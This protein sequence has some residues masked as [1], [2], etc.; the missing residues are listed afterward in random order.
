MDRPALHMDKAQTAAWMGYPAGLVGIAA[1]D[2]DHDPLHQ[3]LC[4]WLGVR[5]HSMRDAA[6]EPLTHDE[7]TLAAIEEDAVLNVQRFIQHAR[8]AGEL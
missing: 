2:R 1:L 4:E 5:S 7:R 8:N 6:G 3:R